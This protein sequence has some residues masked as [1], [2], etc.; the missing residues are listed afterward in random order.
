M[1]ARALLPLVLFAACGSTKSADPEKA[2]DLPPDAAALDR[3]THVD[4]RA[5]KLVLSDRFRAE[6]KVTGSEIRM[7]GERT[8]VRGPAVFT[9][10]KVTVAAREEIDVTWLPD[11][12]NFLLYASDVEKF[13]QQSGFEHGT[14]KVAAVSIANDAVTILP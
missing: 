3:E 4:A 14:E 6:A 5:A 1:S 9:L 10:R 7:E 12:D 2:R 13:T 11:H 8:F